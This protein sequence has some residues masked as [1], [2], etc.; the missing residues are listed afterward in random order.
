M[1]HGWLV[2]V[3][4]ILYTAPAAATTV[5]AFRFENE[6]VIAADSRLNVDD[7]EAIPWCKIKNFGD[8]VLVNA[9]RSVFQNALFPDVA[10]VLRKNDGSDAVD[11]IRIFTQKAAVLQ[12][13]PRQGVEPEVPG[14]PPSPITFVF[15]FF[16]NGRPIVEVWT[17]QNGIIA[18][19]D[20]PRA[21]TAPLGFI[22]RFVGQRSLIEPL[23]N[24]IIQALYHEI[25]IGPT[26]DLLI[27]LQARASPTVMGPVDIIRL[28]ADGG[29]WIQK[30]HECRERE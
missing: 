25:G 9:G 24:R 18:R 17:D 15:G 21:R 26:L 11:R 16:E 22:F 23:S 5:L 10:A 7:R 8:V 27:R 2:L 30:K 20:T 6:I 12:L 28:T 3:A 19:D 1:H 13:N 29:E 4:S 14:N